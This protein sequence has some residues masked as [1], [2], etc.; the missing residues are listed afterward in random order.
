MEW[1][2]NQSLKS[3]HKEEKRKENVLGT[4]KEKIRKYEKKIERKKKRRK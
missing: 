3:D 4:V 1:N 2:E